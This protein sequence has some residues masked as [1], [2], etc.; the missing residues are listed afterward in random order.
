MN[1]VDY[2]KLW[3]YGIVKPAEAIKTIQ[4]KK[5]DLKEGVIS[6][7]LLGLIMGAINAIITTLVGTRDLVGTW[8]NGII[9]NPIMIIVELLVFAAIYHAIAALLKGKSSFGQRAGF[10]GIFMG[11]SV[12]AMLP[13]L[14]LIVI[15]SLLPTSLAIAMVVLMVIG[16]IGTMMAAGI[17]VGTLFSVLPGIEKTKLP[18]TGLILGTTAGVIFI[19]MMIIVVL[20]AQYIVGTSPMLA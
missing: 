19:L 3:F 11:I 6:V 9:I 20:F 17:A 7:A 18:R 13:M 15:A 14:A 8:L 10:F 5:P 2:V 4:K 16:V 12:V 1:V